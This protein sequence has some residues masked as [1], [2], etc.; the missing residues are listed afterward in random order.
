M[1]LSHALSVFCFALSVVLYC[2]FGSWSPRYVA[3]AC[4]VFCV[5]LIFAG[6]KLVAVRWVWIGRTHGQL[7]DELVR[8]T[9]RYA[10]L[11]GTLF[12]EATEA[13]TF[14]PDV[15][16]LRAE[17]KKL[18]KKLDTLRSQLADQERR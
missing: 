16:Q 4:E 15:E 3:V 12:N 18:H 7:Q 8:S 14:P 6:L 2:V 10:E 17:R 5:A 13:G 1:F 11:E 9:R